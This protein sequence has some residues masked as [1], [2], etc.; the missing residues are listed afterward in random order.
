MNVNTVDRISVTTLPTPPKISPVLFA[1]ALIA[2]GLIIA[3]VAIQPIYTL[4]TGTTVVLK[5]APVD[6]YDLLRGY[7]Q[8]LG[9]DISQIDTLSKL[10]GWQEF[11]S[12]NS[13]LSSGTQVYITL[14]STGTNRQQPQAWKPIAV[15]PTLPTNLPNDRISLLG[16]VDKSGRN[17]R[18]G[19]EKFYFPETSQDAINGE[20]DR[21][22]VS[23]GQK[24]LLAEVKIDPQ[25]HAT[26]VSLWIDGKKYQY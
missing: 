1:S 23:S 24:N 12:K 26:L 22:I 5:T 13:I 14:Q 9:Y 11:K 25:G 8:T 19:L 15:S 2:Q 6:P 10:P 7:Y 17:V 16:K 21:P 3:S 4:I 20:I 18:Y